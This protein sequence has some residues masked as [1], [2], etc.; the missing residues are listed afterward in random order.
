[1]GETRFP[2]SPPPAKEAGP[3]KEERGDGTSQVSGWQPPLKG[4]RLVLALLLTLSATEAGVELPVAPPR[5]L[6]PPDTIAVMCLNMLFRLSSIVL[7]GEQ[8][9]YLFRG[10]PTFH[11]LPISDDDERRTDR[12]QYTT[13]YAKRSE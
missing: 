9:S 6:A 10:F 4:F 13:R 8:S 3:R 1:M 12:L 2:T 11:S 5:P 7:D